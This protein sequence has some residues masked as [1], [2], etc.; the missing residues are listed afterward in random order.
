MAA[1]GVATV[2]YVG[3]GGC[4]PDGGIGESEIGENTAPYDDEEVSGTRQSLSTSAVQTLQASALDRVVIV[5]QPKLPGSGNLMPPPGGVDGSAQSARA[6]LDADP[7]L[8]QLGSSLEHKVLA[9]LARYGIH[10][11]QYLSGELEALAPSSGAIPN[12]DISA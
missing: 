2:S 3:G 12:T 9:P 6:R 11:R 8:S 7:R 1:I 10:P 5:K 4:A